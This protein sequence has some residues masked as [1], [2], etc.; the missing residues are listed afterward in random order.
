[1]KYVSSSSGFEQVGD[2]EVFT[3][4]SKTNFPIDKNGYLYIY[5]SNETPNVDV[6]FDNVQVTHV[7]GPLLEDT[8]YYPFG[9]TMAGISS[10]ASG[11]PDNKFEYNGKEKQEKEFSDGIGLDWYDYGARMYDAQIGRWHVIDPKAEKYA[12]ATPYSYAG[13]NPVNFVDYDGKDYGLYFDSKNK[14][15]TI[16]AT[17][18]TLT[19]D[20]ASAQQ[21]AKNWNSQ[22]G[23]NTYTVGKGDKAVAYTVNFDIA[24][25][26]VKPDNAT[27]EMAALNS[28][29]ASGPA[30]E[31]NVYKVVDDSKLDA[32][33]NGTTSGGN[34]I[35]VKDS[36]KNS[37]TGTHEMGH[38]LGLVHNNSGVMTA[39]SSDPKRSATPN[40]NDVKDIIKYPLKGKVNSETN[41]AGKTGIA[42]KGNLVNKTSQKD[43]ELRNGKVQ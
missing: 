1:M 21:A 10:K 29:L 4:H 9:L 43:K 19:N 3:T 25:V 38:S 11:K 42:G 2:N 23:I 37:T 24:V 14:T 40:K 15:I 39:A 16:K 12:A 30:S 34:Y 18:F 31:S 33:T 35:Q 28:A 36:Q 6:F 41:E 8:H 5:V 20:M 27:Q 22:S 13:N 26:E 17:Y 7:R 32:N